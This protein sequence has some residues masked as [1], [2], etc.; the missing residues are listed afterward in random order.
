[1]RRGDG[2]RLGQNLSAGDLVIDIQR[3]D[4]RIANKPVSLTATE[5]KLLSTLL[6]RRGRVRYR[7]S[8]VRRRPRATAVSVYS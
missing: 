7:A 4:V 2:Q 1:L 3:H 8:R 5:F 6:Q